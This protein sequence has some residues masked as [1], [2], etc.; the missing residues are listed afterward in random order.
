MAKVSLKNEILCKGFQVF[1]DKGY[2]GASVRDISSA[3]GVSL[4]TFTG[5]F[6]SKE[7]FALEALNH[8]YLTLKV[9]I[10]NPLVDESLPPLKRIKAFLDNKTDEENSCTSSEYGC[11]IGDFGIEAS[12]HSEQIRLRMSEIF[13]EIEDA[14]TI[15]LKAAVK[16]GELAK[17]TD[18]K[19]LSG[20]IYG[21]LQGAALQSK[22]DKSEVPLKRFKKLLFSN[23][24]QA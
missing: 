20:F 13:S 24:L 3:A 17:N 18:C 16:S 11:K 8:Y 10:L 14:L 5:H 22:L 12:K 23:L 9:N 7:A 1:L 21:S 4:G 15:C 2:M 19:A 6:S